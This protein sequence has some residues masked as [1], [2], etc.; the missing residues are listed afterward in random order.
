MVQ[1]LI[2]VP[3]EGV[4]TSPHHP[5]LQQVLRVV[6]LLLSVEKSRHGREDY[7]TPSLYGL[8]SCR[9]CTYK[10]FFFYCG[11]KSGKHFF[12]SPMRTLLLTISSGSRSWRFR[13]KH[14]LPVGTKSDE[15]FWQRET[16]SQE[17][18]HFCPL[19]RTACI[20]TLKPLCKSCLCESRWYFIVFC[21]WS[22]IISL[23]NENANSALTVLL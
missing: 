6:L 21:Y 13:K 18:S 15:R 12:I 8:V 3:L 11:S 17:L 9:V 19:C 2:L 5:G 14:Q 16:V 10:L 1:A 7:L 23:Y 20:K 22:W 4:I